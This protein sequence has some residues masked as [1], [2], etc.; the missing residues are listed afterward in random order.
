MK[1]KKCGVGKEKK[2]YGV[3]PGSAPSGRREG[4]LAQEPSSCGEGGG[5][6]GERVQSA[7]A[8]IVRA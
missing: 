7:L 2:G 8:K 1:R 6:G 4:S 3:D 5:L